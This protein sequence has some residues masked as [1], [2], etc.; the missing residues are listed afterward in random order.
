MRSAGLELVAM[1]VIQAAGTLRAE[2][3]C[4]IIWLATGN[5]IDREGAKVQF[6]RARVQRSPESNFQG[7]PVIDHLSVIYCT[8]FAHIDLQRRRQL[9]G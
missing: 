3:E 6:R 2:I 5:I 7:I 8:G 9:A 1:P 4:I